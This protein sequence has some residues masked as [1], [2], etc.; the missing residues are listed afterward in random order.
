[1]LLPLSPA[2]EVAGSNAAAPADRILQQILR[3]LKEGWPHLVSNHTLKDALRSAV[4]SRSERLL[5]VVYSRQ[6]VSVDYAGEK[7]RIGYLW[8][9][10]NELP[11]R[12]AQVIFVASDLHHEY[13]LRGTW[14]EPSR[15]SER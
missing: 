6:S 11:N 13:F 3:G 10:V 7:E 2:E 9:F 1:M 5:L 8:R 12:N 15:P 4:Q 14:R